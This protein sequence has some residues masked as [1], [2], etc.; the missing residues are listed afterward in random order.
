MID[1]D[2]KPGH[3]NHCQVCGS[4]ELELVI[5]VGHQPLCDALLTPEQLQKPETSY[6]LRLFRCVHCTLTQLDYVV[7]GSVV[8]PPEYPYRSGITK[9]LEV[10]QRAFADSVV[11]RHGIAEGSLCVDIGSNDGTLLS[12]FKRL[13]MRALGVEPTNIAHIAR[14]ENQI[15]TIQS[16]FTESLARDIVRD[17]GKAKVVTTT[18][19]FAHMASLGE[20]VRGIMTLLD[21]DG[22]FI[23]ESHYLVDVLQQQQFDTIYHE[24]IRTYSLKSLVTLFAFYDCDVFDVQ[25]ADR[26]GGNLRA[27]VCR[28][29]RRPIGKAVADGLSLESDLGLSSPAIYSSFR[30]RAAQARDDLMQRAYEA[31][32]SGQSFVGNSCPG[33]CATL[34][35]Y[36]GMNRD[37]MPY[38]AE[39]PTSLK[40]GRYLPGQ[41]IPIVDNSILIKEQPDFVVL[42]AWHYAKPISEQLRQRGLKSKFVMP[43]PVV[44]TLEA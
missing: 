40:L 4:Q 30:N 33:R 18:N 32:R 14:A 3:L 13:N 25:R 8:Y 38:I 41:H 36:C 23:T 34:L 37:L 21:D 20:V 35:N 39:Q 16:F 31:R 44:K 5:D 19:V 15:E 17:Y 29:G 27:Y 11:T 6:P 1:H 9:E 7:D 42:L 28:K 43:L 10:Y 2:V 22:I 26:Y 24:H 12:G